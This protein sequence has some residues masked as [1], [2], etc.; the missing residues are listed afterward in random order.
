MTVVGVT[1][2]SGCLGRQLLQQLEVDPDVSAVVGIDLRPPPDPTLKLSFYAHDVSQPFGQLFQRHGVQVA[3][4]LAATADPDRAREESTNVAG[5]RE[6]LAACDQTGARVVCVVSS[7]MAYG[8][9]PGPAE[10]LYEGAP[11]RAEA[12]P[13]FVRD[14]VAM[15]DLCYEYVKTH[16]DTCLQ[17]VRPCPLIG[18]HADNFLTRLL[19]ARLV[20]APLGADPP[21][22]L[23]HEDDATRAIYRLIKT[24]KV[25]VFNLAGDGVL[26]LG[27]MARLAERRVLRLPLWLLRGL[28]WLGWRLGL[29]L[30]PRVPPRLWDY[31]RWPCL[32]APIKLRAELGLLFRYD[33]A[34]AFLDWLE[35]RSGGELPRQLGWSLDDDL[36]DLED[37]DLLPPLES[38]TPAPEGDVPVEA[39]TPGWGDTVRSGEDEAPTPVVQTLAQLEAA[40]QE[41]DPGD[42]DGPSAQAEEDGEPSAALGDGGSAAAEPP[43]EDRDSL[44]EEAPGT[45]PLPAGQADDAPADDAPTGDARADDAPAGDDDAAVTA[46]GADDAQRV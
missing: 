11:L 18:P 26:T 16:P 30:F 2:I 45:D 22:Q 25:G 9:I 43:G 3:I 24:E 15:E 20:L 40:Q 10:V 35:A 23:V 6:F 5:A 36:E 21:L 31:L 39:T 12:A 33:S 32:V 1:G 7:A 4:H 14:K 34:Q 41:A 8:A 27:Q 17:I 46:D 13:G 28:S 42:G 37:E 44:A 19:D 38:D 29:R